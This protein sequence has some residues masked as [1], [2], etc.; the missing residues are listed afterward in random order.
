MD[1]RSQARRLFYPNRRDACSTQTGETPVLPKQ[2]R[3][4]F[5]PNR[6]DACST[7]K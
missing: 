6:R 4:L 2:A 7:G 5:Y 1:I 3:R